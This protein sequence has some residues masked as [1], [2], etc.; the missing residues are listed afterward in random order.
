MSSTPRKKT[1][2]A[3]IVIEPAHRAPRALAASVRRVALPTVA[4]LGA[5]LLALGCTSGSA[6]E[7][8]ATAERRPA[9]R[10]ETSNAPIDTT[11][12]PLVIPTT[13]PTTVTTTVPTTIPMHLGGAVAMVTPP[14]PMG[15]T[16]I[17]TPPPPKKVV[18]PPKLPPGIAGGARPT[19]P[20]PGA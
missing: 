5:A 13:I 18:P 1:S 20:H 3:S 19:A 17:A 4:A 7:G 15:T 8:I 11:T 10:V 9:H 12:P 6:D 2:P 14:L 16:T